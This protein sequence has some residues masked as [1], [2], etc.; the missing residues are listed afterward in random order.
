M[1]SSGIVRL[2]SGL[3][4]RLTAPSLISEYGFGT[5]LRNVSNGRDV[6]RGE[7]YPRTLGREPISA[8]IRSVS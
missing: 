2:S 6:S 3:P 7:S 1:R 4:V 8:A 5:Q